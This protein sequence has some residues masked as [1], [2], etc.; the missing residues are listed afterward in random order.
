LKESTNGIRL[1]RFTESFYPYPGGIS[2]HVT[3]LSE[4]INPYLEKQIVLTPF[5]QASD[6]VR[7]FDFEIIYRRHMIKKGRFFKSIGYFFEDL[8]ALVKTVKEEEINLIHAHSWRPGIIATIVGR[9]TSTPV[10]WTVH[11][12][13]PYRLQQNIEPSQL[14][15]KRFKLRP[16]YFLRYFVD[17]ANTRQR[18]RL[19]FSTAPLIKIFQPERI[20][21]VQDGTSTDILLSL[22]TNRKKIV[23]VYHGIDIPEKERLDKLKTR[24]KKKMG[25]KFDK[26]F[27]LI[28]TSRLVRDKGLEYAIFAL[29]HLREKYN[30]SNAVLVII[31]DGPMKRELKEVAQDCNLSENVIFTGPLNKSE[32]AEYLSI[33]DVYLGTGIYG[34][35]NNATM[36]AM[37]YRVPA[38]IFYNK[39]D[40]YP[41]NAVICVPARDYKSMADAVYNLYGNTKKRAELT[42]HAI[43]M[44]KEYNSWEKR[45]ETEVREYRALISKDDL[46][47][48]VING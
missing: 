3:R 27:I 26:R 20:F 9:L 16:F 22:L 47:K 32:V 14:M 31:G 30:L 23:R 46:D 29:K 37:A 28:T 24:T 18:L 40:G 34:N 15:E 43:S 6:E 42:K 10:I 41:E 2:V 13:G 39:W 12:M 19:F 7:T 35:R 1:C 36:E 48:Q 25:G 8:P 4:K 38:V 11:G 21:A 17:C 45:I 33:A 5:L 44:L